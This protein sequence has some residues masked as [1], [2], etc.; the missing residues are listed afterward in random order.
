MYVVAGERSSPLRVRR[1][2]KKRTVG[3]D[4]PYGCAGTDTCERC[5]YEGMRKG[6]IRWDSSFWYIAFNYA[7]MVEMVRVVSS[8]TSSR[9][10]TVSREVNMVTLYSVAI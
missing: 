3:D 10:L 5:P 7:S 9:A 2:T 1:R 8:R 4:G 6:A